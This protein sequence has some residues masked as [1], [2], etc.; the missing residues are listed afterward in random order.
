MW[1]SVGVKQ[2]KIVIDLQIHQIATNAYRLL[3]TLQ[4]HYSSKKKFSFYYL[5]NNANSDPDWQYLAWVI[6]RASFSRIRFGRGVIWKIQREINKGLSVLTMF[7]PRNY[8]LWK[9]KLPS[10]CKLEQIT[11]PDRPPRGICWGEELLSA[12]QPVL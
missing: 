12:V 8:F 7:P 3:G 1:L 5:F 4:S 10:G 6:K 11:I 9:S 2:T